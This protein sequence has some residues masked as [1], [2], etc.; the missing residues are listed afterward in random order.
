M[1]DVAA[2]APHLTQVGRELPA[3][4]M[5]WWPWK[6]RKRSC[7]GCAANTQ[8]IAENSAA[9]ERNADTIAAVRDVLAAAFEAAGKR[10][11][12]RY[13]DAAETRPLPRLVQPPGERD[14][15]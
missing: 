10:L 13:E 8:L 4:I 14:S 15:A 3:G 5:A 2:V 11:P 7:T 12:D 1:L 9:C 6:R